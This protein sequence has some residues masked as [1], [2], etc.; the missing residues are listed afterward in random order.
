[1]RSEA[2]MRKR[3]GA[4]APRFSAIVRERVFAYG[5]VAP[6]VLLLLALVAYP[7][8]Y[9]IWISFT[10]EVVGVEG[11]WV[12]LSNYQNL[13]NAP[14]FG[15]AVRNTI[16]F[17]VITG[18]LKLIFGLGLALLVNEHLRGRGLFRALLML[19]W[20][21]PA[22][23]AFLIW[24]AIYQPIGGGLQLVLA[25]LGMMQGFIDWLGQRSTAMPAVIA[26]A[27]WRGFPFWFITILAGLQAIPKE[28]Y[29]AA[30]VDGANAIDRFIHVTLPGILPVVLVTALLSTIWT[31]NAFD[32]IWLLTQGGPSDAT[33]T[34]PV[35]AYFGMQNQN[36]AEAAAVSVFTLPFLLIF[37]VAA[38][39]MLN[40][41]EDR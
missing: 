8:G 10:N 32:A 26:A 16:V 30:K 21:M 14:S 33:T 15:N 29:E 6:V 35:L 17:V 38:T 9:A 4:K 20:A 28:L 19:P 22:F 31:A 27:T 34:L 2:A 37:L 12:G 39:A 5:L 7:I 36:I 1:M 41:G 40:R 11:E 25:E 3:R 23:V 24:R 18:I 13:L